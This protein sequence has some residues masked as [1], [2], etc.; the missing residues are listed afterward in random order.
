MNEWW[1]TAIFGVITGG[2]IVTMTQLVLHVL[3]NRDASGKHQA[4]LRGASRA[5]RDDLRAIEARIAIAIR[6]DCWWGDED[7]VPPLHTADDIRHIAAAISDPTRWGHVAIAR[8]TVLRLEARR[9]SGY[10]FNP[11]RLGKEF[12]TMEKAREILAQDIEGFPLKRIEWAKGVEAVY[13]E[14]KAGTSTPLGERT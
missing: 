6:D 9:K 7:S 14:P 12:W 2:L 5:L 4:V 11:D 10:Q 8:R 3:S 13:P 1:N